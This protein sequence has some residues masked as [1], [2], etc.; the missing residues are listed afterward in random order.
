M[1]PQASLRSAEAGHQLLARRLRVRLPTA[2]AVA[3][4][5]WAAE[6]GRVGRRRIVLL[7]ATIALAGVVAFRV[8]HHGS[9]GWKTIN[10]QT[11]RARL[12]IPVSLHL[13]STSDGAED[14][15]DSSIDV[16]AGPLDGSGSGLIALLVPD[17]EAAERL[18]ARLDHGTFTRKLVSLPAGEAHMY[19]DTYVQHGQRLVSWD[20]YLARGHTTYVFKYTVL[21]ESVMIAEPTVVTSVRSIRFVGRPGGVPSTGFYPGSHRCGGVAHCTDHL[22]LAVARN[23]TDDMVSNWMG[24]HHNTGYD[25]NS[26]LPCRRLSQSTI[27]CEETVLLAKGQRSFPY[28]RLTVQVVLKSI[29]PSGGVPSGGPPYI[30]SDTVVAVHHFTR[31][32]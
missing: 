25:Y 6:N 1:Q 20:Y 24:T 7:L 29:Y 28:V 23:E 9:G 31:Q 10:V 21:A 4:P 14:W 22:A 30:P 26:P 17:A 15:G 13:L 19:T 8:V 32:Q 27:R 18:A 2:A 3:P 5:L 16:D 11:A 12:S